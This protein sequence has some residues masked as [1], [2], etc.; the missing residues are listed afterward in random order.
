MCRP[1]K[2]WKEVAKISCTLHR[3]S[4]QSL[5][6]LTRSALQGDESGAQAAESLAGN[7]AGRSWKSVYQDLG[8]SGRWAEEAFGGRGGNEN[9]KSKERWRARRGKGRAEEDRD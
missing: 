6:C 9:R 5:F 7:H 1:D 2:V 4:S 8:L 3:T